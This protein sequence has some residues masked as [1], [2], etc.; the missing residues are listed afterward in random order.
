MRR[1]SACASSKNNSKKGHFEKFAGVK[2]WRDERLGLRGK[3]KNCW[4]CSREI[5][6][7]NPVMGGE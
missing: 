1:R 7:Y 4:R 6:Q 2:R 5:I 3:R